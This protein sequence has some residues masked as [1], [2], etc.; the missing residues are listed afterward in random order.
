M[1]GNNNI[2]LG[3]WAEIP[4]PYVTNVL[5][6]AGFDF[7]IIDM[8]HGVI[9]FSIAQNMVFAAHA[10]NKQA[11]IRVPAI[12]ESWVTRTLD[13]GCDGIIFPGVSCLD[14]VKEIVRLCCFAPEGER[15]FNPFVPAGNYHKVPADYFKTENERIKIGIILEGKEVFDQLDEILSIPQIDILYIGQYDLS[16]ALGIPGDV[17]NPKVIELMDYTLKKTIKYRKS[18]GCMVHSIHEGEEAMLKGFSFIVYKVD[19]DILFESVNQFVEGVSEYG[20]VSI[21]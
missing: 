1:K 15:G 7:S 14:E 17:A 21:Y 5:A 3:T 11:F 19:C 12:E 16:M 6:K 13:T 2:L 18:V 8:E 4:S 9:D 20:P 10:A